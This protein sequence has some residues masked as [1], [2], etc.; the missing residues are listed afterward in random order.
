M[1]GAFVISLDF[2][3]RWGVRDQPANGP[4][5]ANLLGVPESVR[6]TLALF[7]EHEIAATWATVGFLFARTRA[8]R[9]RFTP[10][11]RPRYADPSLNPYDDTTGENETD[12]PVHYGQSL[13]REVI[14]TPRQEIATHTFSHFFCLEKGE[15]AKEAFRADIASARSIMRETTGIEPRSIVFPG[16]Q[17]N[18]DFDDVLLEAGIDCYRGSPHSWMWKPRVRG[19]SLFIRATRLADAYVPVGGTHTTPWSSVARPNGMFDVP[20]SFFLRPNSRGAR[21]RRIISA[22]RH[23]ARRH[24]IIHIWWHP[25]NFGTNTSAHMAVLRELLEAFARCRDAMGMASM[26]MSDVADAAR[27]RAGMTRR[28][29]SRSAVAR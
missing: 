26:S 8:E 24:E 12:D 15:S 7:R 11:L 20:A 1:T 25:H 4:Y 29:P 27:E 13:I 22:L 5:R 17:H 28:P 9:I 6:G 2:E 3:K 21:L 16:N 18:P 14:D 10:A 19:D 23:A